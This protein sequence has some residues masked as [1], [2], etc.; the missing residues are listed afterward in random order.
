MADEEVLETGAVIW[1]DLTVPNAEEV[2]DFYSAVIGW[3]SEPVKMGDYNDYSMNSPETGRTI[4]GVCH[5]KGINAD[6]P[7]Q[8][9]IY[10]TVKDVDKSVETCLRNGGEIIAG[11]RNM[12]RYGKYCVIKD[13][14]GAVAALF[15][16]LE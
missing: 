3:K 10:F 14:A 7:H 1:T 15:S 16:P 6:L 11:P 13:P 8:W 4:A 5:S 2:K 12:G 9:L